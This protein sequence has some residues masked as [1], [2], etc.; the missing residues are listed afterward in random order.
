MF[1]RSKPARWRPDW[2]SSLARRGLQICPSSVTVPIELRGL[3]PDGR[4]FHLLCRGVSVR[5]DL[6]APERSG[7]EVPLA[8]VSTRPEDAYAEY[9][10][11]PLTRPGRLD[12]RPEGARLVFAEPDHPDERRVF[13]GRARLGW[14]GHDAGLLPPESAVAILLRLLARD[15]E[16]RAA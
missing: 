6:Y 15:G 1:V 5:L 13:D 7:W 11:R 4:G 3:L 16:T 9:A 10:I 2:L 8:P 14:R 12:G